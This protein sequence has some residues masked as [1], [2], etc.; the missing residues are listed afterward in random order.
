VKY[1]IEKVKAFVEKVKHDTDRY[2]DDIR[3]SSV[4]V[5]RREEQPKPV[6]Q[7]IRKSLKEYKRIINEKNIIIKGLKENYTKIQNDYK[8]EKKR[9]REKLGRLTEE[10]EF[11]SKTKYKKANINENNFKMMKIKVEE[12]QFKLDQEQKKRQ[13]GRKEKSE[14]LNN[15]L[16]DINTKL[17]GIAN[18]KKTH[19][20]QANTIKQKETDVSSLGYEDQ[21]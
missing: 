8:Q 12:L 20:N 1:V 9:I 16:E 13:S 4:Q 21:I 6:S 11:V 19:S 10:L 14:N 7:D 18:S 3:M 17:E 15:I 2:Y 5:G